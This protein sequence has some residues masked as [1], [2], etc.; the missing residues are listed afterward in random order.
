MGIQRHGVMLWII[1]AV[2]GCSKANDNATIVDVFGRHPANWIVD[3]REAFRSLPGAI[4]N[5]EVARGSICSQCHGGDLRGGIAKVSCFGQGFGDRSCHVHPTGYR[6][7]GSH[8]ADAKGFGVSLG[9]SRCQGCHGSR[10]AGGLLSGVSCSSSASLSDPAFGCHGIGAPHAANWAASTVHAHTT[11][12]PGNAPACAQCHAGGRFLTNLPPPP[13]QPSGTAPGCFNNTLCHGSL[14]PSGW[15]N[16]AQH[17]A[18]AKANLIFCQRC[19]ADNPSGGPG[20]NPRFNVAI[21]RL[22]AGCET[23]HKALTAHPPV[24]QIPAVFGISSPDPLGTPWFRHGTATNFDACKLCHGADLDGVNGVPGASRCRKCHVS[25]LPTTINQCR[26][27][28]GQPPNGTLYPNNGNTH[29][30][31]AALNVAAGAL[32]GECHQGLGTGTLDHFNRARAG[33]AGVQG[34][35]VAFGGLLSR[36]GGA[37]PSFTLATLRCDNTYC[38]GTTLASNSPP[39]AAVIL[40]PTWNSP[41]PAGTRC[42][43]CHGFPPANA[44]HGGFTGNTPCNGCHGHVSASNDGFGDPGRHV[45]GVID[46][47]P[48]VHAFP[49]PGSAHKGSSTGCTA[50]HAVSAPGD[51]YPVPAGTPPNCRSCHLA[52]NPGRDPQCSDCHGAAADDVNSNAGR[53]NGTA[54]PN[55]ARSHSNPDSH[56]VGCAICHSGGG[57]GAATHGNSNRVAKGFNEV[58]LA[59]SGGAD[60]TLTGMTFTRV[61]GVVSCNGTCHNNITGRTH[62][63]APETW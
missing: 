30:S 63:H 52:A 46:L 40:S 17:G 49:N 15:I 26:S 12:D 14:H 19:H 37:A 62:N 28:H 36:A 32:C 6:N 57:T 47:S 54:F 44:V 13:P 50:C 25:A 1:I 43:R 9:L 21:G 58:S 41:Y 2:W 45:N 5:P 16:P 61:G 48:G 39:P 8:G 35:P 51:P 18:A 24:M 60:A 53:P 10:Y 59:F 56:V 38:H 29:T 34:G 55:A 33:T 20:S 23:C 42:G 3:H 11:T 22:S 4:D 31:H 27:C 7:P